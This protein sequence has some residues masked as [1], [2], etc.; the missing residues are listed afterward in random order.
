MDG[1]KALPR[2]QGG[3]GPIIVFDWDCTI[4]ATHMFKVLSGWSGY[5]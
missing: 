3:S 1:G 5:C 2:N 4:T